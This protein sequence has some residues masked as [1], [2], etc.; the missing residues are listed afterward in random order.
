M[1][2]HKFSLV[3]FGYSIQELSR[4]RTEYIGSENILNYSFEC[5][6]YFT[7]KKIDQIANLDV[8]KAAV[9]ARY[10][11]EM[12]KSL[13]EMF[14][15]LKSQKAAIV[16]VGSSIMRGIDIEIQEC[17]KEIGENIG[18][19][20]PHVGIRRLDRNKRMLPAGLITDSESQIQQRMHQEYVIGF[21]KP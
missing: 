6:P 16:V 11:S 2:A 9:L 18:F 17:L 1:R 3:W 7:K 15:V 8:K 10:Y 19:I 5:L 13:R 4:K 20:I 14:R 12:T 21:Y